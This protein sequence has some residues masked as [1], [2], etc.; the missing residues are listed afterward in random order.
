MKD[1]LPRGRDLPLASGL[2]APWRQ[3]KAGKDLR[4]AHARDFP[5]RFRI[6]AGGIKAVQP[7]AARACRRAA[8]AMCADSPFA[9]TSPPSADRAG[10]IGWR[11]KSGCGARK[12][13]TCSAPSSGS[14]EQVQIDHPA[15]GLH[16]GAPQRRGCRPGCVPARH[17]LRALQIQNVGMAADGAGCRAGRIHENGVELPAGLPRCDVGD[18]RFGG[19]VSSVP[20]L[21]LSRAMRSAD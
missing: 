10:S 18:D 11:A 21:A 7:G 8:R 6:E 17:V 14:S 4:G 13:S 15:A 1:L 3:N 12:A 9:V 5:R 20:R 16:D 2:A 19:Q